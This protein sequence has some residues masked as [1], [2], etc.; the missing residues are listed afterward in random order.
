[1]PSPKQNRI[2][3]IGAGIAGLTAALQDQPHLDVQIY[4]R[5]TELQEVGATIA[6]GPNG[7]RILDSLGVSEALTD[8]VGLRNHTAR[9]MIYRHYQTDE[10]ISADVHNGPVQYKHQTARFFRPHLQKVLLNHIKPGRLHLSK[11]FQSIQRTSTNDALTINFQDGTSVEADLVFG[12]DGIHSAVRRTFLPGTTAEWTGHIFFRTV[13]PRSHYAHIKDLPNEA[14]HYWGP[15]RTL[16][17]SPLPRDW[18]PLTRA[19]LDATPHIK[20][21]PN[22]AAKE[23]DTWVLG[24]GRVTLGGDAAHAHGGAYAAGGSLAINDAWAFA[25]SV[26]HY[27]PATSTSVILDDQTSTKVLTLYEQTRKPHTD[28]VQ[29]T[30]QQRNKFL[31]DQVKKT[32]TDEQLRKAMSKRD[33]LSW[34]HEH[35]VETAF[36]KAIAEQSVSPAIQ[37]E[38]MRAQARL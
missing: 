4:E 8:D 10:E 16:F 30:V 31:V 25:Q 37:P 22:T 19:V 15:D 27:I 11:G 21:Y 2:A 36:A 3:V 14:V 28:R 38:E 24:D 9:S 32:Q 29:R 26:L 23:L 20:V 18:S 35:D 12:A 17:L 1:M 34:L 6:L 13:V 7:L 5:A 33:H